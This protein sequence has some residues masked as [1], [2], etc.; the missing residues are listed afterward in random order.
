MK[1]V[2]W[3]FSI[4][5]ILVFILHLFAPKTYQ[6]ERK[7]VVT[8]QI[9]TVFKSLCSLKEQQKWSPWAD[10]D[11]DMKVDYRGIDGEVGSVTYWTGNEEV[12][13]GEQEMM[14]INPNTAIE[15][16]LRFFKPIESTSIGFFKLKEIENNTEV[17]WGFRG[18]HKFPISV[19]MLFMDMEDQI[20]PSFEKGLSKF[21]NYIEK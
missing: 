4:L 7:V 1:K 19:I 21:K 3:I 16:E 11:P 15:T 2:I 20:A 18:E 6:V 5:V 10:L 9:D 8:S 14:K 12:G 17:T 13:V